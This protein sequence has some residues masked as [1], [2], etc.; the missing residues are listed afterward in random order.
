VTGH[1]G[2]ILAYDNNSIS[3]NFSANKTAANTVQEAM[4]TM[5]PF[6]ATENYAPNSHRLTTPRSTSPPFFNPFSILVVV[7]RA[8]F[9]SSF[10]GLIILQVDNF[11]FVLTQG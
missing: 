6:P 8:R 2:Q 9:L 7:L 5:R 11:R 1:C 3:P 10:Q 4:Q